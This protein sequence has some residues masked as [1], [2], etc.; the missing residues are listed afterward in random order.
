MENQRELPTLFERTVYLH[1]LLC[2][3]FNFFLMVI[4]IFQSLY[5]RHKIQSALHI[6]LIKNLIGTQFLKGHLARLNWSSAFKCNVTASQNVLALQVVLRKFTT[7]YYRDNL[8]REGLVA[9][10]TH[11]LKLPNSPLLSFRENYYRLVNLSFPFEIL[12]PRRVFQQK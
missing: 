11:I 7:K 8:I 12:L 4:E 10:R 9:Q 1:F 6:S 3:M 5:S 2:N